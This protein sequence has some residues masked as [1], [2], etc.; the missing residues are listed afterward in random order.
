MGKRGDLPSPS[1]VSKVTE[2]TLIRGF[3]SFQKGLMGEEVHLCDLLKFYSH[4][5]SPLYIL[6]W[7]PGVDLGLLDSETLPSVDKAAAGSY[8]PLLNCSSR[9]DNHAKLIC[10]G[11]WVGRMILLFRCL[12]P[13][14]WD[15][16]WN[17]RDTGWGREHLGLDT[18][19]GAVWWGGP[20][21]WHCPK[22]FI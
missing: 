13:G 7:H 15:R 16:T 3:R 22:C 17:Q 9:T 6:M 18:R 1:I 20:G 19:T 12:C 5:S 11:V 2:T 8:G 21:W 4:L 14:E 10:S